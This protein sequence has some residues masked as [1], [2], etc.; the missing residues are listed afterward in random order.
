M[1]LKVAFFIMIVFQFKGFFMWIDPNQSFVEVSQGNW[2]KLANFNIQC[3][4]GSYIGGTCSERKVDPA[5]L[6][7]QTVDLNQQ[8]QPMPIIRQYGQPV[9]I[10]QQQIKQLP[11]SAPPQ[12]KQL[13]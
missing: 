10:P 2:V 3:N 6:Q 7:F 13:Y 8:G 4:P 12:G 9:G 1:K 5:L 11:Y